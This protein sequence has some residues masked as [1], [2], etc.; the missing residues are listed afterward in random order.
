M[1]LDRAIEQAGIVGLSQIAERCKT[2]LFFLC[3]T[4]LGYTLLEE[5]THRDIC[6]ITK[7]VLPGFN[8]EDKVNFTPIVRYTGERIDE[9]LSDQFDP[10][11]N[12][13]LIL[14]PRGTFKCISPESMVTLANG[15][16]KR[17]EYLEV[18]DDV[19]SY[20]K[21]KGFVPSYISAMN[22]NPVQDMRTI[23]LRS[24]RTLNV[25]Y[26]HPIMTISGFKNSE[27]LS[28]GERV[29]AWSG[30]EIKGSGGIPEEAWLLR[31]NGWGW[32]LYERFYYYSQRGRCNDG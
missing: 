1:D 24:G 23:Q 18:G 10:Y 13:L 5:N 21:D 26:N 30:Q 16:S 11:R 12:K 31:S 9:V 3:K 22:K 7:T 14:M 8:P 20:D 4:I 15:S 27:E 29:M 19:L 32:S 6:E 2:D 28:V 17:A 25:S